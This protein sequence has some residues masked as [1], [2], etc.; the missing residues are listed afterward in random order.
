MKT[1]AIVSGGMDSITM[2]YL[3]RSWGTD[4]RMIS[5]DYGQK[6]DKEL[7]F[8]VWHAYKLNLPHSVIDLKSLTHLLPSSSLTNETIG[9]PEGHYA[10]DNMKSTVVPNRNMVMASIAAAVAVN[11]KADAISLGV[12]AGDHTVYPDCRPEFRA[13]L[14]NCLRIANEGFIKPDFHVETPFIGATKA[15]IV[16]FGTLLDVDYQR[17]WSCYNGRDLHCGKCGT[18]VER[19]EAFRDA[20]IDDPT[21]YEEN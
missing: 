6:H 18:C 5:F 10:A 14:Q 11:D 9:V 16:G 7:H 12:H 1:V 8:A 21:E 3:L 13:A 19:R 20:A 15:D 2:V 4:V 17:T